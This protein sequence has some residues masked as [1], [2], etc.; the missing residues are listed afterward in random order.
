MS[1]MPRS[2]GF[3]PAVMK[4]PNNSQKGRR[5]E[6]AS[7]ADHFLLVAAFLIG[8]AGILLF[9]MIWQFGWM[10]GYFETSPAEGGVQA[11]NEHLPTAMATIWTT[12]ILVGYAIIARKVRWT[13]IEPETTGDNCYYLGF[14]F[15]LVSLAVTLVQL[16]WAESYGSRAV[17]VNIISGFGIALVSTIVGILLR[18]YFFQQRADLVAR[19]GEIANELH[20]AVRNFRSQV[21]ASLVEIKKISVE[22]AQIARERDQKL[23]RQSNQMLT[24][25]L[26]ALK[27]IEQ[28]AEDAQQGQVDKLKDI[29]GLLAISIEK[30]FDRSASAITLELSKAARKS[31][32]EVFSELD[33]SI[34]QASRAVDG[35]TSRNQNLLDETA[36]ALGRVNSGVTELADALSNATTNIE[37]QAI[38]FAEAATGATSS[39]EES[40]GR[41]AKLSDEILAAVSNAARAKHEIEVSRHLREIAQNLEGTIDELSGIRRLATSIGIRFGEDARQLNDK[42]SDVTLRLE[43]IRTAEGAAPDSEN[44]EGLMTETGEV[45]DKLRQVSKSMQDLSALVGSESNLTSNRLEELIDRI[46]GKSVEIESSLD[47]A[48]EKFVAQ[49][50]TGGRRRPW[51]RGLFPF[52]LLGG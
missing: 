9:K 23:L 22:S 21:A 50:Q 12:I 51:W 14:L 15:T 5:S 10:D 2:A 20:L 49:G 52:R 35:M 31:F 19:H 46:S 17:L 18:V 24:E 27:K 40:S 16:G 48:S 37:D 26:D 28:A 30:S 4:S 42:C 11:Q 32:S 6:Y 7:S 39:I 34:S 36:E 45:A 41:V 47:K 3:E 43:R 13:E 1:T 8:V 29:A 25:R 38:R 33:S 44:L